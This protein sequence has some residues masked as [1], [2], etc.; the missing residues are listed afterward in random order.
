MKDFPEGLYGNNEDFYERKLLFESGEKIEFI[1]CPSEIY[2]VL[3]TFTDL[4]KNKIHPY[5]VEICY[6]DSFYKN[7]IF[8]YAEH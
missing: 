3:G 6:V 8:E 1:N 5:D 2:E 4:F 7:L